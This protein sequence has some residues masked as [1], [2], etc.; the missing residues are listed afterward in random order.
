MLGLS[1]NILNVANIP[2]KV[3]W[4]F[5][6][7]FL[8]IIYLG[9]R[10][11]MSYQGVLRLAIF[12]LV[13]FACVVLHELG[14]S[15]TARRYNVQTKDIIIS[16]IGGVARLLKMPENPREEF[17]IA[18]AGPMVNLVIAMVLGSY[19]L[20][21]TEQGLLPVGSAETIFEMSSNFIP[22]LFL[23]NTTLIIFN[24][25]PAF[26]MDGGRIFRSLLSMRYGKE[27]ATLW[28]SRIGQL[29][30]IFFM[31]AGFYIG[32]YLLV[33]IGLFVFYSAASEYSMVR[34]EIGLQKGLVSDILRSEFSVIR[35]HDLMSRVIELLEKGEEEDFIVCS[36]DGNVMGVL[37]REFIAE[38]IKQED[39]QLLASEYLSTRFEPISRQRNLED[40]LQLFQERGYSILPVFDG[41][42]LIG[43]IDRSALQK[44]ID[45]RRYT[46]INWKSRLRAVV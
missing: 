19:L 5:G 28:A 34:A 41:A 35:E 39:H 1:F 42:A 15:L 40:T 44:F 6:F 27:V 32:D 17:I 3:H 13:L 30:A 25:L 14:H 21:F 26:P 33:I 16:P 23:L 24:L 2:I 45:S 8:W 7:F 20:L 46:W 29:I 9:N 4:T 38:A 31:G 43:V 37:H 11:G 10:T 22:A 36:A 18:I 12:A